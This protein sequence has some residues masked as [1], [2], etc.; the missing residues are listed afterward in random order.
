MTDSMEKE[1][2][3]EQDKIVRFLETGEVVLAQLSRNRDVFDN[4]VIP[5]EVLVLTDGKYM[6][7]NHL[8][9]YVDKYNVRLPKDIENHI[10]GATEKRSGDARSAI[11][12][13]QSPKNF[14]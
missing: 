2:Y 12:S 1:R 3:A 11:E 8:A 10:L 6:W 13:N 9:Y 7:C 5:T 14:L 4:S